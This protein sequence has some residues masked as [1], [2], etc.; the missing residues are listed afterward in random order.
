M[1]GIDS[2]AREVT[3]SDPVPGEWSRSPVFAVRCCWSACD[4]ES[5][6]ERTDE[7]ESRSD[8]PLER[9]REA[10]P[11]W[12]AFRAG[13]AFPAGVTRLAWLAS[14]A[15]FAMRS[16]AAE[17]SDDAEGPHP[18]LMSPAIK[19]PMPYTQV[20]ITDLRRFV[21]SSA[22]GVTIIIVAFVRVIRLPC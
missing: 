13:V 14:P 7:G 1:D 21:I 11:A 2:D 20:R 6:A 3:A 18:L 17:G 8:G 9:V 4:V 16:F 22:L 19:N 10:S 5:G 12:L 15:G